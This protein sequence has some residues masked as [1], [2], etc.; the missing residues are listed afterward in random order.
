MSWARRRSFFL[1]L[2]QPRAVDPNGLAVAAVDG[3]ELF[4]GGG[5][6][7]VEDASGGRLAEILVPRGQ[8]AEHARIEDPGARAVRLVLVE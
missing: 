4:P 2:K 6:D 5:R 8:G 7:G 1:L 3:R